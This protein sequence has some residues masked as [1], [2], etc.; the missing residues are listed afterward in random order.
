LKKESDPIDIVITDFG[1][2]KFASPHEAMKAACGTLSYVAPEVLRME[3]Y[4]KE[5]DIWS[6]GVIMYLTL[7]AKL[8]FHDDTKNKIIAK[9]LRSDVQMND[10]QWAKISSEA[11]DLINQFLVKKPSQRITCDQALKH[12][13]FD[14]IRNIVQQEQRRS[15]IVNG[16]VLGNSISSDER[17]QKKQYSIRNISYGQQNDNETKENNA[18]NNITNNNN[19]NN[20]NNVNDNDNDSEKDNDN[21]NENENNNDNNDNEKRKQQEQQRKQQHKQCEQ[22]KQ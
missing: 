6:C 11:K 3:G 15:T 2:S 20:N 18:N 12:P 1:L 10:A 8:P 22:R 9:I 19:D 4:G 7:R 5:V 21:D 14:P 16:P 17:L 13:W